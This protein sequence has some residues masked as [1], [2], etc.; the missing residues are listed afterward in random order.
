MSQAIL[1]RREEA[2][3]LGGSE[4][5]RLL[6]EVEFVHTLAPSDL[7]DVGLLRV[8]SGKEYSHQVLGES[9]TLVQQNSN[10]VALDHWSEH[11]FKE[12]LSI[13][14]GTAIDFE[15]SL[16]R[17]VRSLEA[18]GSLLGELGLAHTLGTSK[19]KERELAALLVSV[20]IEVELLLDII[21]SN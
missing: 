9:V 7:L 20:E 10:L 11:L 1:E 15:E 21:L 14:D 16:G 17:A 13:L 19:Q 2:I 8:E 6:L 5:K 3:R 12:H 4:H 18:T